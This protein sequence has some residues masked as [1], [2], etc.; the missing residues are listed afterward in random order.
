M[1]AR[2]PKLSINFEIIL[3]QYL[4]EQMDIEKYTIRTQEAMRILVCV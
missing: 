2:S 4:N 1:V 3:N